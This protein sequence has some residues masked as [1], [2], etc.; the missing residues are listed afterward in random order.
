MS[1]DSEMRALA[2]RF[3]DL[4]ETGD[5]EELRGVY[6]EDA[7]IWYNIDRRD[8]TVDENVARL[9]KARGMVRGRRYEERRVVVFPG[10]FVH[11]HMVRGTR[12]DGV[13]VDMPACCICFVTAGRITRLEE[14]MD[15]ADV[16]RMWAVVEPAA[17]D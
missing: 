15:S 13:A 8:K 7:R 6:A 11:Q 14:Y 9:A 10:G 5:I 3:F 2:K 4:I 12:A 1:D 17:P 16:A